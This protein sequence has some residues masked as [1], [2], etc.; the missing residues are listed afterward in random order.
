VTDRF[1]H[2]ARAPAPGP[3]L[4]TD[5]G[6]IPEGVQREYDEWVRPMAQPMSTPRVHSRTRLLM[7]KG[8]LN[9][10]RREFCIDSQ[11]A[12]DEV[13]RCGRSPDQ[14]TGSTEGLAHVRF[15]SKL[16]YFYRKSNLKTS[17]V[18]LGAACIRTICVT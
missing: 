13:M 7:V 10:L 9:E 2:P 18:G 5:R 1:L 3:F 6:P 11:V 16:I 12:R 4:L 17:V 8:A 14:A 15:G